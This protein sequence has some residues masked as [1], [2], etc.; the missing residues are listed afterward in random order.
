M[1]VL[2]CTK[3]QEMCLCCLY[4]QMFLYLYLNNGMGQL[5]TGSYEV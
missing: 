2:K 1:F 5:G 4:D 3:V